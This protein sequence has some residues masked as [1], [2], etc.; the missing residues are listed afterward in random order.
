MHLFDLYEKS[1]LS[2]ASELLTISI[3][4]FGCV[5]SKPSWFIRKNFHIFPVCSQMRSHHWS[6]SAGEF[7]PY[8]LTDPD[9]I[10][11][12][13]PALID[14]PQVS[15][16]SAS[17]RTAPARDAQSDPTNEPHPASSPEAS[18]TSASPTASTNSS[19]GPKLDTMQTCENCHNSYANPGSP[20]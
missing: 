13:H 4:D 19:V 10:V 7:H 1:V 20:G 18:Y 5:G 2:K 8:A 3:R 16:P 14:Q 9:M 12:H 15:S 17:E 6:S 11:S